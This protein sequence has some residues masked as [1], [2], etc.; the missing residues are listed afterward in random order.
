MPRHFR[1]HRR[2]SV[3]HSVIRLSHGL[4]STYLTEP[5]D[6]PVPVGCR[7]A[8][9]P[10]RLA[11]PSHNNPIR[12]NLS[13]RIV[14]TRSTMS[15]KHHRAS[16]RHLLVVPPRPSRSHYSLRHPTMPRLPWLVKTARRNRMHHH[17]RDTFSSRRKCL[18][19]DIRARASPRIAT[20][21]VSILFPQRLAM[22]IPCRQC[23][24]IPTTATPL[25]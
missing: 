11:S 17:S 10:V 15:D 23:H 24:G 21:L 18:I 22:S 2:R 14:S 13:A 3:S 25:K 20:C 19:T 1:S 7:L 4:T 8:W 9:P 12:V 6:Q 5:Q 16:T